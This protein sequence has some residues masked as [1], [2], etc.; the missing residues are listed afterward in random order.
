M[1]KVEGINHPQTPVAHFKFEFPV[2]SDA[3]TIFNGKESPTSPLLGVN[4]RSRLL[5]DALVGW[6][7]LGSNAGPC[8]GPRS[9]SPSPTFIAVHNP[10]TGEAT[11]SRMRLKYDDVAFDRKSAAQD[12]GKEMLRQTRETAL[13]LDA[14]VTDDVLRANQLSHLDPDGIGR[15]YLHERDQD[16][17]STLDDHRQAIHL[18]LPGYATGDRYSLILAALVEPRLHI[19][20]AF[21]HDDPDQA[22]HAQEAYRVLCGALRANGEADPEKRISLIEFHGQDLKAARESLD[23]EDT[24]SNFRPLEGA[25]SPL[26]GRGHAENHMFHVSVSTELLR[27]HFA[28]LDEA[29]RESRHQQVREKLKNLVSEATR[30]EIDDLIDKVMESQGISEGDVALWVSDRE[31]ANQREAE[32]ISRP[33]MFEQ[34]AD[35]IESSGK[36]VFCIAD[37]FINRVNRDEDTLVNRHPYRPTIRPHIGRFWAAELDGKRVLEPR[38]NQWYFMDRLLQKTGG[39][40]VGIRSGAL[41]PFALM[42]HNVVYLE[43]RTMF[44]PERHASWQGHIPYQRLC[45]QNTTGYL[46]KRTEVTHHQLMREMLE[47]VVGNR[48]HEP[49]LPKQ[50]AIEAIED[51]LRNGVLARRELSLLVDM[52]DSRKSAWQTLNEPTKPG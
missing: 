36:K 37:T 1:F 19:S 38:E 40:L 51:D 6:A 17:L 5:D 23:D 8:T 29:G 7:C 21:T 13:K 24:R 48:Q 9:R 18:M 26:T 52:L 15:A 34:I 16:H 49:T 33:A 47:S 50:R 35:A 14:I 31:F 46:G 10:G 11:R 41:E 43:H 25:A 45:T 4:N 2:D 32:A 44:T 27:R 30:A 28:G 3:A 12:I 42:G 22:M 39:G 20:V